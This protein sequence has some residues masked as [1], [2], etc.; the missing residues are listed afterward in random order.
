M[1]TPFFSVVI[2]TKGRSF[3]VGDA[4][5]SVLRQTFPDFEVVVVDNDDGDA[6][7]KVLGQFKDP[8]FRH[9]R[10]GGLPM[11]E[12]WETACTQGKGEFLLLLEDK[13]ALH[14]CA[15]EHLYKLIEKH[16]PPCIRWRAD[17]FDDTTDTTWVEEAGGS[18]EAH[19]RM[20]EDVLRTYVSGTTDAGWKILPVG[21]WSAFSRKLC[22][23]VRAGPTGRLCPPVSPDYTIAI[24]AMAFGDG[25]LCVDRALAVTS[26]RH[27]NGRSVA[28]KTALGKQFMAELGGASR[29]WSRTPI[30]APIIS[31]SL[32]NDYLE[33]REIIGGRLNEFPPDWVNYYVESWRSILG[34]DYQGI[35]AADDF[36]AFH[37]A[38]AKE[39]PEMQKRVWTA[40]EEREAP[41]EVSL[42]K[43][44]RKALRRRI[45]LLALETRWKLLT[46]R[47]TGR[48]HVGKF[49]NSLEFAIW[50]DKHRVRD[51]G[52]RD[53]LSA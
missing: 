12:N 41:P 34:L 52:R 5:Q 24:Q 20:S 18:G 9:H 38:L 36:A 33:L 7:A 48:K 22:D 29:L 15:L 1:K 27:S 47:V 32:Y 19:F 53:P 10:T 13:Q 50:A 46:R 16:Q 30:Q 42:R 31:S 23:A 6:T 49:R 43:N 35:P 45:G 37:A 25:V 40:I 21:H 2:P 44:R 11:P 17:I 14:S 39:T 28:Q 26:R 4:V 8:R 51:D 3:I